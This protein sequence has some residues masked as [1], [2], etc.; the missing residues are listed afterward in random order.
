VNRFAYR[1]HIRTS[2]RFKPAAQVEAE[3]RAEAD[4]YELERQRREAELLNRMAGPGPPAEPTADGSD[5]R[6]GDQS[7]A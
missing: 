7:H 3:F 1:Y 5:Q 4:R 2:G 6:S